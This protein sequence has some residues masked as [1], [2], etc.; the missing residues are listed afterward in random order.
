MFGRLKLGGFH[1]LCQN[2]IKGRGVHLVWTYFKLKK[3]KIFGKL[4][5]LNAV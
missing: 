5:L 4:P 1:A 2:Q 3:H